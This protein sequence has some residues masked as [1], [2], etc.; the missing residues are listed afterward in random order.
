MN[1]NNPQSICPQCGGRKT[2]SSRLCWKCADRPR[3][4]PAEERFWPKVN[5]NGPIPV[6]RPDLGS[7]WEWVAS[8][9]RTGYGRFHY[10]GRWIAAFQVSYEW[11][12]GPIPE[13]KELDH[14]CR[15]RACVNPHHLEPVTH[16]E[17]V[18]RGASI[19]AHHAA[20][21]HCP[22]GHPY[23]ESNTIWTKRGTR[24][25]RI[26]R[27]EYNRKLNVIRKQKRAAGRVALNIG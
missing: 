3:P 27:T 24:T 2:P 25:C 7:C 18:L 23:D 14:L 20:K 19:P 21:T 10:K 5:K 8:R 1:R 11:V 13:G 16:H 6:H 15:N 17:N 26:C 12:Y 9:G 4:A 22:N